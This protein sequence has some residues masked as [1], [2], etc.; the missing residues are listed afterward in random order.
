MMRF[1]TN[2]AEEAGLK[3]IPPMDRRVAAHLLKKGVPRDKE[4]T[5]E[6][7]SEQG[8]SKLVKAAYASSASAAEATNAL[9]ML[10]YSTFC[11]LHDMKDKPTPEQILM[12][13]RLQREQ[14]AYTVHVAAATGKAM[15]QLIQVERSRWLNLR[16]TS[17][18][19]GSINQEVRPR[20]LFSESLPEMVVRYEEDKN[21]RE[22]LRVLVPTRPPESTFTRGASAGRSPK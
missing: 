21:I 2:G 7:S 12:L 5:F 1:V 20:S 3:S 11:L 15:A 10:Q 18:A 6:R 4:P 17:D 9:A 8:V 19:G 14:T 16:D 13:R 22:A